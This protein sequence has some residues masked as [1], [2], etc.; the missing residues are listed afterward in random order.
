LKKT[1]FLTPLLILAAGEFLSFAQFG[2]EEIA[3]RA[4]MEEILKTA[5]IVKAE[6]IGEGVTNPWRL[7]LDYH[8]QE[9]SGC[10]KNPEGVQRGFLEG[11]RFEIA[12]YELDKLLGLN[13]IPATVEREFKGKKG[14]LQLWAASEFSLLDI[15]EGGIP[16]PAKM[17]EAEIFNRGKYLARAFDSLIA[18]D[19]RTQ[20]NTLL[21]KDWRTILIDHSRAFRSSKKYRRQLIYGVKGMKEEKL[22]KRLPRTFIEKIKA[23]NFENIKKAVGPYLEDDEIK[24]VLARREL[25]LEQIEEMIKGKGENNVLY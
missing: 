8:G 25:L 20:Q 22:F 10:W 21:T 5:P 4:K 6:E 17:P 24:A 19:D 16:L 3:Q 12:A 14:S 23:L 9:L 2:P 18:N 1:V 15:M 13:M 11:W 7:Y